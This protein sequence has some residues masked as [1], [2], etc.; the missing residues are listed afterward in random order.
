MI[1]LKNNALTIVLFALLVA[2][3]LRNNALQNAK[4]DIEFKACREIILQH[5]K[6][7]LDSIKKVDN[8]LAETQIKTTAD[9]IVQYETLKKYEKKYQNNLAHDRLIAIRDSLRK[10]AK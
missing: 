5:E 3:V 1:F 4:N 8:K 10:I 2:F 9:S 7:I 6:T